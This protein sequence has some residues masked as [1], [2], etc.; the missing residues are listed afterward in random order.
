MRV[1]VQYPS[2]RVAGSVA[3]ALV[4]LLAGR[5]ASAQSG[6]QDPPP[7]QAQQQSEAHK[8]PPHPEPFTFEAAYKIEQISVTSNQHDLKLQLTRAIS[9]RTSITSG[10]EQHSNF[11]EL[12]GQVNFGVTRAVNDRVSLTGNFTQGIAAD[13]VAGQVYDGQAT[14]KATP[15]FIPQLEYSLSSFTVTHHGASSKDRL[16]LVGIGA[17]IPF[18]LR[19]GLLATYQYSQTSR[20]DDGDHAGSFEFSYAPD[21]KLILILGGGYGSERVLARTQT[22]IFR[23]L[24]TISAGVGFKYRLAGSRGLKG[25][26]Q[27]QDRRGAYTVHVIDFGY[28]ASF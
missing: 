14:I 24:D 21:R 7:P 10:Y 23:N 20:G 26:Y 27:Y 6:M 5:T 19:S 25:G 18:N 15:H 13:L 22:E 28:Y 2:M 3:V 16:H 17:E 8:P 11:K 9:K 12:D 4:V 1:N